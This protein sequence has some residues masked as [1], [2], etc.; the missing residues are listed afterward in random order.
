MPGEVP[1]RAPEFQPP[2]RVAEEPADPRDEARPSIA[3]KEVPLVEDAESLARARRRDD[4]LARR[5]IRQDFYL[6]PAA[7]DD[8]RDADARAGDH[9]SQ[10]LHVPQDDHIP[11]RGEVRR[12][13]TTRE[14]EG[15]EG[16]RKQKQDDCLRDP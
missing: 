7:V 11:E 2:D 1:A 14:E 10:V 6:R 12:R 15:D 8:R 3:D 16:Q 5:E 13:L 9:R 4:G